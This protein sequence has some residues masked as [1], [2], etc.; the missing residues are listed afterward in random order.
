ME[1]RSDTQKAYIQY[2]FISIQLVYCCTS[3]NAVTLMGTAARGNDRDGSQWLVQV[4][5]LTDLLS[6]WF[7]NIHSTVC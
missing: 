1:K 4:L 6:T 3:T 7:A 2:D 5:C